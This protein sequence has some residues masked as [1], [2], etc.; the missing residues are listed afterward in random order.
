MGKTAPWNS[1]CWSFSS[2]GHN[3]DRRLKTCTT[4]RTIISHPKWKCHIPMMLLL[5]APPKRIIPV[6]ASSRKVIERRAVVLLLLPN[7]FRN[8]FRY[9][10]QCI[11]MWINTKTNSMI[12]AHRWNVRQRWQAPCPMP[13]S[14]KWSLMPD[15]ADK[16]RGRSKARFI[17]I[18]F[19]IIVR[20][21]VF[22]LEPFKSQKFNLSWGFC[23]FLNFS[24]IQLSQVKQW[25]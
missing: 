13:C 1:I 8:Q 15:E 10:F 19:R 24:L 18:L 14:K 5:H 3:N 16:M 11:F 12:L 22:S 23:L 6:R 4:A 17:A 7:P 21:L 2:D 25:R 20:F 9:Q